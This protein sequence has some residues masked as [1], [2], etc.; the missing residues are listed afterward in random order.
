[1][2]LALCPNLEETLTRLTLLYAR[3]APDRIF[4]VMNT[5]SEAL[6]AFA[7]YHTE[8]YCEYPDLHER[9]EFW[10]A[11][12]ARKRSIEDD[13]IP[14]VYLSECDQGLYGGIVGGKVRYMAHPENGWISSM[15]PPILRNWEEFDSIS[16]DRNSN[17][18]KRY[19]EQL[20]A[21]SGVGE[22]QYGISHLILIDSMNFIFELFGAESA[23]ELM[24]DR[25]L[26]GGRICRFAYELNKSVQDTF[27]EYGSLFGGTCSNMAQWLPGKIISESVDPFHMT[28]VAD[29]DRW[30][31]EWVETIFAAYDG[32][33]V[34]IHGNGRHLLSEVASIDGMRA[35]R[36][37]DDNGYPRSFEV[38]PDIRRAVGELPLIVDCGYDDF[39]SALMSRSLI[40]G[41]LYVVTDVPNADEANSIMDKV[42][43]YR[44]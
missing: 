19:F 28:S 11:H 13:S 17:V 10:A 33:V 3:E 21:Y 2:Q 7:A 44:L 41:V 39:S 16:V 6:E 1:M 20:R 30:G 26:L 29:F 23:Y 36:L 15:V 38:L 5:P 37:G 4:A 12:L 9:L 27:F 14:S 8:G 18:Y 35:I 24:L 25:P 34:H 43:C 42:R 22:G 32:G 40:G 31:R